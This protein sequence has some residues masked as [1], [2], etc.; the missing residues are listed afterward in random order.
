[1]SFTT[2][3]CGTDLFGDAVIVLRSFSSFGR[4]PSELKGRFCT[5]EFEWAILE[6]NYIFA[7]IGGGT[8]GTILLLE[9]YAAF[10]GKE[11]L[12]YL[13]NSNT[14]IPLSAI[15]VIIFLRIVGTTIS[16]YSNA[17]GGMFLPLMS[18][19]AL[20]GYSYGDIL[21]NLHLINEPFYFAAI[22]AA[23]FMGVIMKLPLTAVVLS[24]E[25]TFDYN[26]VVATGIVLV[27]VQYLSSLKFDIKRKN[28]NQ[29]YHSAHENEKENIK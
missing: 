6:K 5:S 16:I 23:V 14:H 4:Q 25:T 13:I 20:A 9:P 18:I 29:P 17:V 8:V 10:S 24:L 1:V 19:G 12:I 28:I 3:S 26:V 21:D 22:G 27:F 7:L 11:V 2:P 15:F